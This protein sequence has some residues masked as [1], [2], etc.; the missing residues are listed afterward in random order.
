MN[1]REEQGKR[2]GR[3]KETNWRQCETNDKWEGKRRT[4]SG[5]KRGKK[6]IKI[7]QDVWMDRTWLPRYLEKKW[8]GKEEE[9]DLVTR[10][11]ETGSGKQETSIFWSTWMEDA[12]LTGRLR[13]GD[14]DVILQCTMYYFKCKWKG[15]CNLTL[16]GYRVICFEWFSSLISLPVQMK[17]KEKKWCGKS[18]F[19]FRFS[20]GRQTGRVVWET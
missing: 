14:E 8:W 4:T 20:S 3:K 6:E 9:P 11:E 16:L 5:T 1:R 15:K 10:R 7:Q 19:S 18:V 12:V 2:R 13:S 17:K